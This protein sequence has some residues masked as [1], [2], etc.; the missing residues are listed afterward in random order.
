MAESTYNINIK[1]NKST[2]LSLHQNL[3]WTV[4][5]STHKQSYG[6]TDISRT[7]ADIFP[8]NFEDVT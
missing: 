5:I 4:I 6:H 7:V 2:Q 8:C 3:Q 1:L